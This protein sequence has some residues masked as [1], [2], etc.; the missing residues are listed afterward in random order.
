MIKILQ[1]KT[2]KNSRVYSFFIG[3]M[4]LEEIDTVFHKY[5]NLLKEKV[6]L[7]NI[8]G[9]EG[10]QAFVEKIPTLD[11]WGAITD[12][13]MNDHYLQKNFWDSYASFNRLCSF[14]T[15]LSEEER[16]DL[17]WLAQ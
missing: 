1:I 3:G 8:T 2:E 12:F 14:L 16:K 11:S 13:I 15:K 6:D 4:L 17:L 7:Q 10:N 9:S 5:Y